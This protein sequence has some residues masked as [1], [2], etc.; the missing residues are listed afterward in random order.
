[1]LLAQYA[2]LL[3]QKNR[4]SRLGIASLQ[5]R[6]LSS[7]EAFARTLAV[8]AKSVGERTDQAVA[9]PSS[10]DDDEY[11]EDETTSDERS[12]SQM[13]LLSVGLAAPSTDARSLLERM[14]SLAEQSRRAPGPKVL[15]LIDWIRRNQCKAVQLGGAT[16]TRS[17]ATWKDRRL[18]VFT[19]YA[20]TKRY[21]AA[22]LRAAFD[23]TAD[24]ELRLMEFHGG[25]SDR[26]REEVQ[27]AFN[28]PPAQYPVRILLAT[29]AAREGV[30]LQGYCADI[31]HF[32][33]P[34]NPARLEQ[35]NGRVDRT[36]QREKEVR[37]R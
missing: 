12:D 34:W 27:R 1:M 32:D 17:P 10:P 36:L 18:I 21:L 5:K 24:G 14:T 13:T 37:C 30:N 26:Q 16:P 28:G 15:A 3:K 19:E 4:R 8:H 35:R 29:D 11:G 31:F 25:M 20:D 33:V 9:S 23:G 7:I 22:I 6:L 2:A